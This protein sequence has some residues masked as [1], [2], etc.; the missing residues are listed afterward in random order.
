MDDPQQSTIN[1]PQDAIYISSVDLL[2]DENRYFITPEDNMYENVTSFRDSDYYYYMVP[3]GVLTNVPTSYKY[4]GSGYTIELTSAIANTSSIENMIEKA[5]KECLS[6]GA[7]L[8]V[9]N[10]LSAGVDGFEASRS[11][12]AA[13]TGNK[14]WENTS[15][16]S[17]TNAHEYS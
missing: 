13:I 14:E 15:T 3:V 2:R 10:S 7:S 16:E 17:I 4:D 11:F 8:T 12:E 9:S 5:E 1:I 6:I